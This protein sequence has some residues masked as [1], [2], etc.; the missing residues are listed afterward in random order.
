MPR[1]QPES[2]AELRAVA[3]PADVVGRS[4]GEH[5]AGR[6]YGRRV[7]IHITRA[8][9][10]LGLSPNAVT[11]VLIVVGLG[12]AAVLAVGGLWPAIVGVVLVQLYLVLDCVDGEVA[13]WTGQTSVKGIY[14]DRLG[15]YLVEAQSSLRSAFG[16]WATKGSGGW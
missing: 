2:T 7:S 1:R 6:L 12:G 9:P 11:A 15:H 3:Q 16:P 10:R 8:A 5:W 4:S 13:R 14:L